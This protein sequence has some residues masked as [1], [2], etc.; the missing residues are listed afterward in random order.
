MVPPV[1][2]QGSPEEL[3]APYGVS[4][5]PKLG[6]LRFE[7]GETSSTSVC[8]GNS[9]PFTRVLYRAGSQAGDDVFSFY[10]SNGS[11]LEPVKIIVHV[12]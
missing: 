4:P 10:I 7:E 6:V 5:D 2:G 8:R 9:I 12:R 11:I 3:S 1:R